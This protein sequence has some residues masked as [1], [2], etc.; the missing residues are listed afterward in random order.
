MPWLR[1]DSDEDRWIR[2]SIAGDRD[3]FRKLSDLYRDELRTFMGR[4]LREPHLDD[5]LQ[6][7][8]LAVWGALPSFDR[9]SRFKTWLYSIAI[10]KY[11]DHC[12][13]RSRLDMEVSFSGVDQYIQT[14][15]AH[16]LV[17]SDE[18][19]RELLN[20]LSDGQRE[21]I[22]L[23]YCGGLNLPEIAAVIGRNLNTVKY[24]F[25]RAH[26]KLAETLRQDEN[27]DLTVVPSLRGDHNAARM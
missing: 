8:W 17:D 21:V 6:E 23:Y 9:R 10:N 16:S 2:A 1:A 24:Q 14:E 3:A 11:R 20:D 19:V 15:N 13:R 12:R 25:Y 4:R 22:E 18:F 7:V 26:S 5:V 27:A